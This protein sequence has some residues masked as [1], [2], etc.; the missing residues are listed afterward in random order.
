MSFQ[1][2]RNHF[3]KC[4]PCPAIFYLCKSKQK[5]IKCRSNCEI[6]IPHQGTFITVIS[7]HLTCRRF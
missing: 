2:N 5:I 4:H 6:T 3:I 7:D 1:I